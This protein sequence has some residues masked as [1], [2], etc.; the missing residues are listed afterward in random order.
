MSNKKT[1]RKRLRNSQK[2]LLPQLKVDT[3]HEGCRV[4]F[5][6]GPRTK[7]LL[8][9]V[10]YLSWKPG[11]SQIHLLKNERQELLQNWARQEAL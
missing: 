6:P 11:N 8:G 5:V 2:I 4:D 3:R 9:I 1:L 10:Q 7:P